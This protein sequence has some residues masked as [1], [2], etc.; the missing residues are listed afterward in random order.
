MIGGGNQPI[1]ILKEGTTRETG[2]G[3]QA[4]NIYAAR[5][6]ANTVKST[7][8]PRGMDK[9]LVDSMGDVVITND[10]ATIL[11]EIDVAHPAAKMLIEVAKTQDEQAG[12]GTTTSVVFTGELLAKAQDLL[13]QD[14]HAT[15]ITDGYKQASEKALE[16]ISGV[17]KDVRPNDKE[18]L[19]FIATTSLASK[20]ASSESE[21]LANIAVESVSSIVETRGEKRVVDLDNIQV[22][23]AHGGSIGESELVS[24][25]ILDKE[26][27]HTGMPG[28]VRNAKIA[29]VD[30]ALE[31]KKTEVDAKIE[32][33]NPDQLNQFLQEEERMLKTMVDKVVKSGANVLVAQKGIDDLAQ[34]YLA[35]HGIYAIRRAKKSDME[36]LA[37]ATGG[38]IVSTLDDLDKSALGSAGL[39]EERKVGDDKFTF[40]TECK[41][42]KA[43]SIL[44][45]GGT[46]H[47]VDELERAL[48]DALH[49]V[50]VA[51]ED[52]KICPG[53]GAW[54]TEAAIK[55]REWAPSVGGR[56]Q[57]AIEAFA[58]A[59]EVIPRTLAENAG[60]DEIDI[61]IALRKAHKE[62]KT[63][64]GLNLYKGN[65][66]DSFRNHVVEPLRVATQAVRSATE[67]A[68]MIL[69]IDD[70]IASKSG[71]AP[72]GGKG[73]M[74]GGDDHGHDEF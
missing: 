41:N 69:R 14:I 67:A 57:M 26:R 62:G 35:K 50:G 58:D 71:G 29:L 12:D 38:R 46:E 25:I 4:N 16:V 24:G 40:V 60:L 28:S 33:T 42:P 32:I 64:A 48:N 10:G 53:G 20:A 3:A 19:R 61:L 11:K 13:E 47:V 36:K 15:V 30:A 44:L 74:P 6:I 66:E 23:K 22:Q 68:T 27:V 73:G 18:T 17:A 45:R 51:I 7:L 34:H 54:Q 59:L 39:V 8:G 63:S 49:V 65:V 31:I 52:G 72:G 9:M 55:L 43:V 5:T 21:V 56:Q 2:R 37:K 70:V 1:I